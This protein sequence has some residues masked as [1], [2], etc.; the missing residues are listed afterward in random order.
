MNQIA[1]GYSMCKTCGYMVSYEK[2]GAGAEVV[3]LDAV[4]EK[5]Y[6]FI[7]KK[8]KEKFPLLK[9]VLDVGSSDGHFLKVADDEGFSV[10]GLEPAVHLAEKARLGGFNVINGFFPGAESLLNKKYDIIIFNDSWEHIPN[11]GESLQGVRE[12]LKNEGVVIIN[13]PSS[14][15]I[16][17]KMAFILNK[18]GI[19]T[20]FN[21]LW[22][23]GFA[24]PHLHYFNA[25]NL[26]KYFENNGF[27]TRYSS[28]LYYYTIKGLWGRISCK[29]SFF[30]SVF[31]WLCM[32]LLYPLVKLCSDCFMACFSFS[33]TAGESL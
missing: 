11:L 24:S 19:R 17:F 8:I 29:S 5:N 7:C 30:V 9:T 2:P 27:V 18:F 21:R 31:A 12:H 33:Q 6:R 32:V 25:R 10:T 20:P 15:G 22:Q 23:K 26:R 14:D 13:L 1:G 16:I 28:P 4:R 3:S